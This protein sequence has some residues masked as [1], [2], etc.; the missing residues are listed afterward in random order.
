MLTIHVHIVCI[1]KCIINLFQILNL[2]P[3]LLLNL[4]I[5]ICGVL[6]LLILLMVLDTMFSSLIIILDL[7]GFI[8]FKSKSEVFTKFT[9]FKA[10][11]ET[12]FSAKIKIFRSDGG[13]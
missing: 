11:I 12:P 2:L 1:V 5:Q 4:C 6:H 13:W 3:L 9:Y 10:M 8:C 7:H